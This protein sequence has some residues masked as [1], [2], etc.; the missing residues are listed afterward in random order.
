[1]SPVVQDSTC[2]A[3][4]IEFALLHVRVQLEIVSRIELARWHLIT[5]RGAPFLK[6]MT[7]VVLHQLSAI[8]TVSFLKIFVFSGI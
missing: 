8:K 5:A 3:G 7:L 2:W 1:M 4:P 6:T